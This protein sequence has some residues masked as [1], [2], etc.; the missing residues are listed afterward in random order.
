MNMIGEVNMNKDNKLDLKSLSYIITTHGIGF[1]E[2]AI[3]DKNKTLGE[4]I[5]YVDEYT[6][7]GA[8]GNSFHAAIYLMK[9]LHVVGMDSELILTNEVEIKKNIPNISLRASV[10]VYDNDKYVVMN[11][12]EDIKYFEEN[13][14]PN[15]LREKEYIDGSTILK[16]KKSGVCSLDAANIPLDEFIKKYGS[17][18]CFNVGNIFNYEYKNMS[19][20]D[21]LKQAKL[22]DINDYI[23]KKQ[24][25]LK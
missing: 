9:L 23:N 8:K 5:N 19:L 25:N 11:P 13:K 3:F 2:N 21:F 1:D 4:I 24:N 14:I 7:R 18:A 16:G 12:I 6:N 17:G 15:N 20:D 22:I 10:L